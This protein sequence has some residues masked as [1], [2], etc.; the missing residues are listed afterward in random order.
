MATLSAFALILSI[1]SARATEFEPMGK[2][3]AGLLGTTK[4][5]KKVVAGSNGVDASTTVF[6]S[7]DASGRADKL[8]FIER[9]IYQPNCSHTWAI[10][11]NAH[12]GTVEGIHVIEMSCPHAFPT[13]TDSYLEQY[14]GK[15]PADAAKLEGQIDT[16]AKATGSCNL[17][18]A[19]VKRSIQ[20]A[21][22]NTGKF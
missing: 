12:T 17:T 2:A 11:I 21:Q 22:A 16:I 15:G 3:V 14:K 7:K 13:H 6:V 10:G 18:T 1:E 5:F 19:A 4:A 8:V 9:G 20:S